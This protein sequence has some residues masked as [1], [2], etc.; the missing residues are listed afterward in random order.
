MK[1]IKP[2]ADIKETPIQIFLA[3]SIEMGKA[4][5]WQDKV[6]DSLKDYDNNVTVFN[7]RRDDW[8]SSWEQ[9]ASNV[10]FANQVNWELDHIDRSNIVFFYFDPNT[11]SP[12]TL[13]ELGYCLA[14]SRMLYDDHVV[15]V[16]PNGYF[17]K[18]N[19]EITCGR[20]GILVYNDLESGII[21]LKE[22]INQQV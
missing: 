7:P 18:G 14:H 9:K 19:I 22:L 21:R 16:C 10:Q 11:Q 1:H 5:M 6:A 20:D 3:G 12:I 2:L 8:D 17:R 13:L 15:V 4:E